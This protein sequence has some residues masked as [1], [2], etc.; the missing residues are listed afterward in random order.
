MIVKSLLALSESKSR[1]RITI[2]RKSA[3]TAT[4]AIKNAIELH[5]IAN[6]RRFVMELNDLHNVA[7]IP[8]NTMIDVIQC[9]LTKYFV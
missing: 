6:I 3:I 2:F 7:E 8:A 9:V 1:I 5:K 4:E